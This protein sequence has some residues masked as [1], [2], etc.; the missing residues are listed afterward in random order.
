MRGRHGTPPPA[1]RLDELLYLVGRQAWRPDAGVEGVVDWL[2]RQ[3]GTEVA[4]VGRGHTV[5]LSTPGFPREILPALAPV[6]TRLATGRMAAAA[7]EVGAVR[8][9]LEGV[10]PDSPHRVLVLAGADRLTGQQAAAASHTGHIIA[11]LHRARA[12]DAVFRDYQEKAHRIRVALFMALMAGDPVLARRMTTGAVP[13][14]L[15]ADRIR[16]HLLRCR[17]GERDRITQAHQDPAGYHGRALMVRCPVYDEHLI[18]LVAEDEHAPPEL[19]GVLRELV[20][21]SEEYALGVSSPHPLRA[22]AVAYEEAR[23]ALAVAGNTPGRVAGYRSQE[24]L[25]RLLPRAES[26]A[27]AHALLRPLRSLP[28]LTAETTRLALFFPRSGVAALLGISRNTVTAHLKRSEAALGLDLRDIRAR[29]ALTLA[30]AV[31]T[32][33]QDDAPADG[34]APVA[35][36]SPADPSPPV[37]SPTVPSPAALEP[38]AGDGTAAAWAAEFLAPLRDPRHQRVRDTLR[39]W[40]ESNADARRTAQ[41][42]GSSRTTV[43]ARLR[44]AERLLGRDLLATGSGV[45]NLVYAFHFS[46]EGPRLGRCDPAPDADR[47]P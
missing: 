40:V 28:E 38:P 43:A 47:A 39:T 31:T 21:E 35:V 20:A 14:L 24:P 29:A 45:H 16:V 10:G 8:V 6:L 18:C 34:R 7:T 36:P 33:H 44:T 1:G 26:L 12:A 22:T 17:P 15:G 32:L 2:H 46:G 41:R 11:L 5:E 30:L 25:E 13:E 19:G 4:L 27:W 9:R 23:H 37:P 42:L 3:L